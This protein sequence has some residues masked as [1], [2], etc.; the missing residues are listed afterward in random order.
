MMYNYVLSKWS[1]SIDCRQDGYLYDKE[2]ILEYILKQKKEIARKQKEY[3]KQKNR[4]KVKSELLCDHCENNKNQ[5]GS[6][7]SQYMYEL[8]FKSYRTIRRI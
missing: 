6:Q 7:M 8:I 1:L 5:P 3:E 4:E 2:A